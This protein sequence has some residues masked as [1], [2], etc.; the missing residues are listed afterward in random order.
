MTPT[1]H[2]KEIGFRH[3]FVKLKCFDYPI[4]LNKVHLISE[5]AGRQKN[6]ILVE[7][8]KMPPDECIAIRT[9]RVLHVGTMTREMNEVATQ[10]IKCVDPSFCYVL[11]WPA[12]E[13][14]DIDDIFGAAENGIEALGMI[15]DKYC[16]V[17]EGLLNPVNG[18][19]YGGIKLLYIIR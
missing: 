18:K 9:N 7:N 12:S 19:L 4:N 3:D 5:S 11:T 15:D 16:L 1:I 13:H 2:Q 10:N 14:A 8:G 17:P 6:Y